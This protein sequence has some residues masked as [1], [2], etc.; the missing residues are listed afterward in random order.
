MRGQQRRVA[1]LDWE[2]AAAR[3][4]G[5]AGLKEVRA[6][7]PTSGEIESSRLVSAGASLRIGRRVEGLISRQQVVYGPA[8]PDYPTRSSLGLSFQVTDVPSFATNR[9]STCSSDCP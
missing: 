4:T 7:A 6:L 1:G 2:R 3:L 9:A 5:R 8:L